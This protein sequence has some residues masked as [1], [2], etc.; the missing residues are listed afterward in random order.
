MSV[1]PLSIVQAEIMPDRRNRKEF[2]RANVISE[3][4]SQLSVTNIVSH[5]IISNA[6]S[7]A[8]VAEISRSRAVHVIKCMMIVL[9]ILE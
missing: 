7:A 1:L 3:Q 5:S 2:F 9:A 6:I 4:Y 8:V